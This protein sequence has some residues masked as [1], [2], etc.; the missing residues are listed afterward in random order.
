MRAAENLIHRARTEIRSIF[1]HHIA[2]QNVDLQYIKT[3]L[4]EEIGEFLYEETKRR[5]MVIPVIIEV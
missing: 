4:R 5:P 1:K 3:V 2:R